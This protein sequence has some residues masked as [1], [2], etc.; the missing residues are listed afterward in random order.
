MSCYLDDIIVTGANDEEHLENLKE[1]FK[2]LE[3]QGL[4]LKKS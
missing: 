3:S 2:R 1:V 4:H